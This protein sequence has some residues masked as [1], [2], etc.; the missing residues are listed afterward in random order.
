MFRAMLEA[1]KGRVP[2]IGLLTDT[3]DHE[4]CIRNILGK[5]LKDVI[6]NF[7][8]LVGARADSGD[9]EQVPAET[10]EWLMESFG[11]EVNSKGFKVLPPYIRVVQGDGLTLETFRGLYIE[12]E[13]R[14]L[15]ADNV[16]CGMGG[17]LLQRL[18]R[19]TL[20]FGQKTNAVC[21]NGQW[22][23]VC[24]T[25]TGSSMKHS[26]P[27]R[28]ALKYSDDDYQ[29]VRKD[30]IPAEENLLKPVFR[31]GKLLHMWNF[32]ELIERSE[33]KVP[34]SYYKDVIT[35]MRIFSPLAGY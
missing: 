28:L 2:I 33:R 34:E 22:I 5:E 27:G 4:H 17:G 23:D 26:K 18:N 30:S 24:K 32:A 11:Y 7:P 31:N 8:G 14:G 29:T 15:S 13:R 9:P 10:T 35:P 21:I 16:F 3:Y 12:L 25:P 1:Y 6:Q 20:N 19:D